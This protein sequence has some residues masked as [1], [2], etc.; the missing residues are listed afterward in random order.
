VTSVVGQQLG[1]RLDSINATVASLSGRLDQAETRL[2]TH[3]TTLTGVQAQ[4]AQ[5]ERDDAT[6]RDA[7]S[8]SLKAEMDQ[9]AQAEQTA[10]D[11]RFAQADTAD[12]QRV[13]QAVAD[14]QRNLTAQIQTVA[15]Q[16][17][18][19]QVQTSLAGLQSQMHSI[20]QSEIAAN[21]SNLHN[22]VATHVGQILGTQPGQ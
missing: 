18:T 19:A 10:L 9:R 4:V 20:A 6:A 11:T 1:T 22:V 7:L 12:A 16:A 13:A 14:T 5:N 8:A 15:T 21:Q 2:G 3:D 17:A